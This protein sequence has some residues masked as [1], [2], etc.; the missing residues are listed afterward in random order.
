MLLQDHLK[1]GIELWTS[2]FNELNEPLAIFDDGDNLSN[3]NDIFNKIFG[4]VDNGA[5]NQSTFYRGEKI[6]EKHSYPVNIEGG[7]YTVCHYADIGESLSLRNQ[8]IQN[9]KMSALGELGETGRSS[10]E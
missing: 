3:S 6:F 4:C 1:T 7:E 2:T 5:L 10:V 8:M 9:I